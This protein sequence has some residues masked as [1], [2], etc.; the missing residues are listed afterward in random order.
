MEENKQMRASKRLGLVAPT[1][2]QKK[3]V[4]AALEK[5]D[6]LL[7]AK[8]GSGKTLT[9]VLPMIENALRSLEMEQNNSGKLSYENGIMKRS[10]I[11]SII[12]VP[13]LELVNQVVEVVNDMIYFCNDILSCYSLIGI[14]N[15]GLD[16]EKHRLLEQPQIIA[17]KWLQLTKPIWMMAHDFESDIREIALDLSSSRFMC[18]AT[19]NPHTTAL[20][21]HFLMHHPTVIQIDQFSIFI[22]LAEQ[23]DNSNPSTLGAVQIIQKLLLSAN[24]LFLPFRYRCE[25]ICCFITQNLIKPSAINPFCSQYVFKKATLAQTEQREDNERLKVHRKNK[26][27]SSFQGMSKSQI[28]LVRRR[29]KLKKIIKKKKVNIHLV[30]ILYFF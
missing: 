7:R 3:A 27:K 25:S 26:R 16:M 6:I 17:L 28:Q 4:P 8:T 15:K 13:T 10:R 9:F 20:Q 1:V 11:K 5:K 18:S 21:K 23:P 24:D 29:D 22:A 19:L 12:L 30:V 2:V 14:G